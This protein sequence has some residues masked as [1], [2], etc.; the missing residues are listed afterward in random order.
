MGLKV[1]T[2]MESKLHHQ[3]TV[4]SLHWKRHSIRNIFSAGKAI[5]DS[6]QYRP[7]HFVQCPRTK[8]WTRVNHHVLN[9][10]VV[11]LR[12]GKAH[13]WA[14]LFPSDDYRW[15][16]RVLRNKANRRRYFATAADA[17]QAADKA[18]RKMQADAV[19]GLV[20]SRVENVVS[21]VSA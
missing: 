3:T 17:I 18:A 5:V 14:V 21:R 15:K 12:P 2:A 6:T 20:R 16:F 13:Q 1:M 7:V 9:W 19:V 10:K 8:E 4:T 11:M